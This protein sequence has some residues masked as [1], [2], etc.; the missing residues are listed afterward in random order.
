MSAMLQTPK[1]ADGA[2]EPDAMPGVISLPG[3]VL[4]TRKC[5]ED[6]AETFGIDPE[7]EDVDDLHATAV[8]G[9][10]AVCDLRDSL[11]EDRPEDPMRLP[12]W[13]GFM[14]ALNGISYLLHNGRTRDGREI[15][16]V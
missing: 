9:F 5:V 10:N 16:F 12:R 15:R 1:R 14:D 6:I 4:F 11:E 13:E 8:E 3:L 7:S 2:I